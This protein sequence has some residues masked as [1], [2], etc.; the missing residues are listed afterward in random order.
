MTGN[1][2]AKV[3]FGL[4][5]CCLTGATAVAGEEEG[6]QLY[7]ALC[8]QCHG[9]TGEGNGVNAS[10]L[11]VA[12]RNH[13]DRGEMSA[14]TDED[15]RKAI[16]EGGQAINKSILMPNWGNHLDEQEINDLVAYLRVL[17]CKK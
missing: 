1:A 4:L 5:A 12:P 16:A 15:L 17:C 3:I 9:L 8:S 2:I 10:E 11:E 7:R 6:R 14:R 13:T